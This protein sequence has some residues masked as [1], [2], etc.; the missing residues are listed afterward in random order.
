MVN[1]D[2]LND[3][4]ILPF[5]ESNLSEG[6]FVLWR[7]KDRQPGYNAPTWHSENL[8]NNREGKTFIN[9]LVWEETTKDYIGHIDGFGP[10][11]Y[12]VINSNGE[13][14]LKNFD[15][16]VSI[17][18]NKFLH[19]DSESLKLNYLL[20][21][22]ESKKYPSHYLYLGGKNFNEL[23]RKVI[24]AVD[25]GYIKKPSDFNSRKGLLNEP[26]DCGYE[27]NAD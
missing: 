18:A 9:R 12:V 14:L 6:V 8:Y 7:L 22:I 1:Y 16:K 2:Y 21:I 26:I 25:N 15:A 19:I 27:R 17:D 13:I 24:N 10:V 23:N 20:K 5:D 4:K 3:K 11:N